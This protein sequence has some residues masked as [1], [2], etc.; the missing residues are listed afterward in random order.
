MRKLSLGVALAKLTAVV[1]AAAS[2]TVV[3]SL[4]ADAMYLDTGERPETIYLWTYED[5]SGRL[6]DGRTFCMTG[7]RCDDR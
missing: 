2:V 3:S 5:G 7:Q 1:V 6:P 4:E